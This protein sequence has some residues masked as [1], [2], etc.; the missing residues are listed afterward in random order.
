M[1]MAISGGMAAATGGNIIKA[2]V[3][4]ALSYGVAVG[5]GQVV[6]H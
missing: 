2:M 3:I 1:S 6:A 5:V 4:G